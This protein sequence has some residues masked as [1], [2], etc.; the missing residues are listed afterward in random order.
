MITAISANP[1]NMFIISVNINAP[2]YKAPSASFLVCILD[3]INTVDVIAAT[4]MICI[5]LK[6]YTNGFLLISI[7]S[8]SKDAFRSSLYGTEY[9]SY[10]NAALWDWALS[11]G[12]ESSL[13]CLSP[14]W[15]RLNRVTNSDTG[16]YL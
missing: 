9:L 2:M 13:S 10:T 4:I 15:K 7:H 6:M 1:L 3:L 11:Y 16:M 12:T 5:A 14:T 8:L